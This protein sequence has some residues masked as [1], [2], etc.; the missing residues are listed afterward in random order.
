MRVIN[1]VNLN[2][3]HGNNQISMNDKLGNIPNK[4]INDEYTDMQKLK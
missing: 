2:L 3:R 4:N 1:F